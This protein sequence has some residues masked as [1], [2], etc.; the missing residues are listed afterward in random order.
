[1][2]LF[3][4]ALWGYKYRFNVDNINKKI[5]FLI[6]EK[7]FELYLWMFFFKLLVKNDKTQASLAQSVRR[8]DLNSLFCPVGGIEPPIDRTE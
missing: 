8:R 3:Y 1:V 5:E 6:E 2:I 7:S 4:P